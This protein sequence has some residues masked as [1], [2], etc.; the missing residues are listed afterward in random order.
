MEIRNAQGELIFQTDD[1]LRKANLDDVDL[2]GAMLE[3][4]N[5]EGVVWTV[6]I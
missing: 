3:N 5:L 2:S 6:Q 1:D 4:A